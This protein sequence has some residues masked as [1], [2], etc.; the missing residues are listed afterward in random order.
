MPSYVGDGAIKN[1]K[2]A[3]TG[4]IAGTGKEEIDAKGLI[5]APGFIDIHTHYD[6]QIQ[7]DPYASQSCWHGITTVV[8]SLCGFGFA[9]AKPHDHERIMRRMTG[10][11]GRA[12]CRE[13]VCQYV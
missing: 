1:G 11:I 3:A 12:S 13:R 9:P 8:M 2:I 5:V 10:E 7:W 4:K 6:A